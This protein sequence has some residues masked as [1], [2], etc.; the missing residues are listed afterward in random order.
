MKRNDLWHNLSF[1]PSFVS[2]FR[3][4]EKQRFI[5]TICGGFGKRSEMKVLYSC[6][7]AHIFHRHEINAARAGHYPNHNDWTLQEKKPG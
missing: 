7:D 3:E 6:P 2:F 4:N 5:R 1:S